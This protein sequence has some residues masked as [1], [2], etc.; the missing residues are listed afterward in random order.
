MDF[1]CR[2]NKLESVA[3]T[4]PPDGA[5]LIRQAG[6]LPAGALPQ[7][8]ERRTDEELKAIIE[9]DGGEPLDWDRLTVAEL[10]QIARDGFL[11]KEVQQ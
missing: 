3:A 2:L 9:A 7:W 4:L 1:E 11:Q 6:R 8:W 5:A 10:E